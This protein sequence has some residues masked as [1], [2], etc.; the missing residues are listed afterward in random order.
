MD[1]SGYTEFKASGHT[2]ND[3]YGKQDSKFGCAVSPGNSIYCFF[4]GDIKTKV[5]SH[6]KNHQNAINSGAMNKS[7]NFEAKISELSC[8]EINGELYARLEFQNKSLSNMENTTQNSNLTS[9]TNGCLFIK[10]GATPAAQEV[11]A[12]QASNFTITYMQKHLE[13]STSHGMSLEQQQQILID[14]LFGN[15]SNT[16]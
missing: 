8:N 10:C 2:M 15:A 9:P 13:P 14:P 12:A 6:A 3:I 5:E 11:P 4:R 1:D 7:R 16:T